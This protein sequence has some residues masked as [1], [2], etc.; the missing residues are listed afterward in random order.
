MKSFF[1][2]VFLVLIAFATMFCIFAC[3]NIENIRDNIVSGG[4]GEEETTK[5]VELFDFDANYG[6]KKVAVVYF[7]ATG[8]TKTVAEK[9]GEIFKCETFAIE[10]VEAYTERDLT[11]YDADTRPSLEKAFDPYSIIENDS[12][13]G[14]YPEPKVASGSNIKPVSELP[15]IKKLNLKK[16]DTIILGYPIWFSDAPRVIY[17]FIHETDLNKKLVI[18]FCTSGSSDIGPSD[19]NIANFAEY[20][21]CNAKFMG[22]KRFTVDSTIDEIKGWLTAIGA[23]IG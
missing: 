19:G 11:S 14:T 7:S 10:P 15:K 17:T 3:E 5:E 21:G 13:G 2:K 4:S 1:K 9:F 12:E 16:Y 18:P 22:G 23:D 6:R 8:N 20:A